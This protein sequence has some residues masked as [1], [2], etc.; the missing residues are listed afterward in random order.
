MFFI[1]R[2]RVHPNFSDHQSAN[3]WFTQKHVPH[4]YTNTY[5]VKSNSPDRNCITQRDLV[6]HSPG[7]GMV[8]QCRTTMDVLPR[9]SVDTDGV[10]RCLLL[11]FQCKRSSTSRLLRTPSVTIKRH[12]ALE[13][14]TPKVPLLSMHPRPD[15]VLIGISPL[16]HS[17][18]QSSLHPNQVEYLW[19]GD[20]Y[21]H[22]EDRIDCLTCLF[23]QMASAVQKWVW[24]RSKFCRQASWD[25]VCR[26]FSPA[27]DREKWPG[28]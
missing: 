18:S 28:T 26:L 27:T 8:P 4:G 21:P 20:S 22:I 12:R 16:H 2:F 13:C 25:A 6:S 1:F 19:L 17:N 24:A 23:H 7:N 10:P 14:A 15:L 3:W 5:S 11:V 9:V